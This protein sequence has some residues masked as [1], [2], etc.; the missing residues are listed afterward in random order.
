[1]NAETS[2]HFIDT[3]ILVYAHDKSAGEKHEKSK[4]LIM[5][6]WS[7]KKGCLSIQVLQEFY[8]SIVK[9]VAA[10][11]PPEEA[12]AIIEHLGQWKVHSPSVIDV[13]HATRLQQRYEISF[14]D[15]M[16]VCSAVMMDCSIL[17][18]EDMS[19]GQR[20]EG[21]TVRNPFI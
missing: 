6:L 21:V 17:W 11:V 14:W 18:S 19:H 16:V 15:A 4:V 8:V 12:A 3:N 1:M 2:R 13:L 9:K 7:S 5:D 20:Y 10:P